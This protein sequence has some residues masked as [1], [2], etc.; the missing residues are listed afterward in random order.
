MFLRTHR[1]RRLVYTEALESYREGGNPKHRCFARWPIDQPF[2]IAL[3]EARFRVERDRHQAAQWRGIMDRTVARPPKQV[4][5]APRMAKIWEARLAVST[6]RLAGL[7]AV[8]ANLPPV[9]AD[10]QAAAEA[11][12]QRWNQAIPPQFSRPAP[13][14]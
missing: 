13:P 3:G 10:V 14:P 9:E 8:T 5:A 7:E 6:A 11:A 1:V 12:R 2:A 4:R